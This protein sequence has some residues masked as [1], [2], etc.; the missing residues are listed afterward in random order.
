MDKYNLKAKC[1]KCG[2]EDIN[3]AYHD[4]FTKCGW[5]NRFAGEHM[6]RHCRNC[7][8]EWPEQPLDVEEP[9]P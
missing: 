3:S 6:H 8:Y 2:N 1:P 9:N 7:G 5:S 4:N